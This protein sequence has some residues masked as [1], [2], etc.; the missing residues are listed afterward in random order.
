MEVQVDNR[1]RET[2]IVADG[3]GLEVVGLDT[4]PVGK[5]D[6]VVLDVVQLTVEEGGVAWDGLQDSV[7]WN[8]DEVQEREADRV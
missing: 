1:E 3:S 5:A 6:M 7:V 4:V 8:S 2:R